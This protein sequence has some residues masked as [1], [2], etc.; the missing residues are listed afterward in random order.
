M[1]IRNG[2]TLGTANRKRLADLI[3]TTPTCMRHPSHA[4]YAA[5]GNRFRRLRDV[6]GTSESKPGSPTCRELE[7]S[8]IH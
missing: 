3:G 7:S 8:T 2:A 1:I 6:L 4:I 5:A